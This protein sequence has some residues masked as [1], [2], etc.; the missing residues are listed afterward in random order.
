MFIARWSASERAERTNAPPF[1]IE[2]CDLLGLPRPEPASGG[3]GGYRFERSVTHFENDDRATTRRIDLYKRDCFI[4]EAKQ[5]ANV[6]TQQSLFGLDAEATRRQTVRNSTGWAQHMLKA[7]GQAERYVRDLPADEAAPPFLI[8]CDVGFCFDIYAD[9]SGTGRH[10]VQFPDRETFRIY[11][12]DLRRPDIRDR[13]VAIWQDPRSLDPARRRTEVTREIAEYLARLARDLEA[14]YAPETVAFFLMR[15]LFCMF[16]QSVDLLPGRT[17]FTDLLERC[18]DSPE[19]FV[20]LVGELWRQ[21]NVGGFSAAVEGMVRRFNGGLYAHGSGS[22]EPLCVTP[23]EIRLLVI[24]AKRDWK[25]VDPA[26]FGTLL[27]NALTVRQR[28][29]LGAH[30]TPRAF[31]ERLVIPAVMEPLRAEWDGFKAASYARLEAGDKAGAASLL[32]DFHARLCAVRVLDPACGTGNFLYVTMEMMKRLE[33]E[34]LDALANLVAGEGDR[35]ALTGASVDPHQF[36]GLEKNPRAVPVAELVLWIGYLQWHFRTFG[37]APP[38]EPILRDFHNIVHADALMTSDGEELVR[39]AQGAL[40]TRWD[41]VTMKPHTVTGAAVPDESARVELTR[42]VRPRMAVW[43]EADFIVGNPPFIAGKDMRAELGDGYTTALWTLYKKV[44]NSADIAMFFWWKAAQALAVNKARLRRFGFIT[45]NS[46]RQTFCRRVMAE[47]MGGKR[48]LRLVFAIPDHPWS[49]GVGS[50]AVRIA[51]TVAERVKPRSEELGRL[52]VVTAERATVE[53]VPDVT[54]ATTLARINADLS[55]GADPDQAMPLQA[56]EKISSPGVKLHGAGFIVTP[57]QAAALGLGKVPGLENHIRPYLNGRDL[58]QR[59][60]GVMVIDLFGL[61]EAEV[62]RRFSDVWQYLHGEVYAHRMAISGNT[63]DATEYA[64]LWWLHGKPRPELRRALKG[65]RRYIATV[66]TAKH[67][68]FCFLPASVIPDNMLVCIATDDAFH[69]GV[70]SSRFHVAWAL[71]AGGTLEDRPRYNKTRC[72]DPFP[73][74]A[75]STAQ[76]ATIA[77]IAEELDALRRQNLDAHAELTMTGLYNVLEKLRAGTPLTEA[78]RDIHDLG[79]ISILLRLHQALDDAV[80]AA[81]GWPR[82]LPAADIVARVVALNIARRAEEEGGLVRW[83]RPAFQAPAEAMRAAAQTSL[84]TD[85]A[86]DTARPKWPARDPDRFVALRAALAAGPGKPADLTRHFDRA[87]AAR[88]RDMLE[89]LAALG[90]AS[91]D[92]DGRYHL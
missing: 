52:Q 92:A 81:Y 28:G 47:A 11:T 59:S 36:L 75:A 6:I 29:Q 55:T 77:A 85:Q 87:P 33:G 90:Q 23:D 91:R 12:T 79:K 49:D 51:M 86:E 46:I 16:A 32:R 30:F 44:P 66:E 7:R 18:Q 24:A 25:N 10:Y 74:P 53:G 38:A 69:L 35:L 45:S 27:E 1:L 21:M 8:V 5:G 13:L 9:F 70:L 61:E 88:V 56:N 15:C 58:T 43:P 39:D 50:A 17:A 42:P 64:R 40:V 65:L 3:G 89:T 37:A 48:A 34:V 62:R 80:A 54:L 20:G 60:R 26:I 2:L 82:D 71:A 78:E 68:P 19:K 67:R 22:A 63:P 14:R 76:R 4:L 31:V 73:F 41:G 72:F 57:A 83:L 84:P